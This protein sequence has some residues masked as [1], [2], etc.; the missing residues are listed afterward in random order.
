M[1]ERERRKGGP[2]KGREQNR[3]ENRSLLIGRNPII[4]ALKS[5]REMEK[6]LIAKGA[7]GSVVK[8]AAMAREMGVPVYEREKSALDR[9]APGQAHQGVAA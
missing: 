3:E 6:I 9:I 2:E 5:G 4:E 8:I 1:R 7:G